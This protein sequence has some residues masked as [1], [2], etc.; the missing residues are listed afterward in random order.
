MSGAMER[1]VRSADSQSRGRSSYFSE[2]RYSSLPSRTGVFS[3]SSYP[4]YTP[5]VGE[6][7]AASTART[8]KARRPPCWR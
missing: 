7:V 1:P 5:Q 4:A 3:H 6:S 8:S 2:C